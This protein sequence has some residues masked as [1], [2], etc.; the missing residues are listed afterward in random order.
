[1]GWGR[2]RGLG[3][4]GVQACQAHFRQSTPAQS[5]ARHSWAGLKGV[6]GGGSGGGGGIFKTGKGSLPIR[7]NPKILKKKLKNKRETDILYWFEFDGKQ[8]FE[9][10]FHLNICTV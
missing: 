6:E 3:G 8:N 5:G 10:L 2:G 9:K 1:M 7:K 4:G